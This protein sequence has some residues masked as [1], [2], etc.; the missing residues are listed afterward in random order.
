[1]AGTQDLAN[2]NDTGKLTLVRKR[3]ANVSRGMDRLRKA[4]EAC[5]LERYSQVCAEIGF[6]GGLN[7]VPDAKVLRLLVERL[8][9]ARPAAQSIV[10]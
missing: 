10:Q 4:V 2:I 7:D 5:G 6:R 9:A 3:L 1:V 8:E